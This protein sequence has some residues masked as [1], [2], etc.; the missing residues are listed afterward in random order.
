MGTH[1]L[2]SGRYRLQIRRTGLAVNEVFATRA[3][4]EAAQAAYEGDKAGQSSRRA[5]GVTLDDAWSLYQASRAYLEKRPNS[6]T[7]E[8]SHIKPL[9]QWLGR[10]KVKTLT[11][12]DVDAYITRQ[13]KAGQAANTTRLAVA[14][15][16][17]VLNFCRAKS[18]VAA[19]VCI[20]VKR[21]SAR[22]KATR[23]PAGHQGALMTALG[24]PKYRFRAAARLVVLVRETG[25]RP[26][27]WANARWEWLHLAKQNVIFEDTKYKREPRTV[28]L[29]KDAMG[30]LTAQLEDV[31]INQLDTLGPSEWIFPVAGRDG[32]LRPFAYSGTLRDMKK[33][34]LLPTKLRAH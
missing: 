15:L 10:R 13:T 19:N 33:A 5:G 27:E 28:P 20:G 1:A 11:A 32:E 3:H 12:D 18:V 9:L 29:N 22:P 23:M 17:S 31:A 21:P 26:G 2:P 4:A 16:S 8:E 14:A 30:L 34:A 7:S 6:K 24:H 25:A